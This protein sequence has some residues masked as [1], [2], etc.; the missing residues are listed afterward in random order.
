MAL[1]H[2]SKKGGFFIQTHEFVERALRDHGDSV[3]R[4]AYSM[5]GS[6][7][8][9]EDAMQ[10]TFLKLYESEKT[11][12]SNKHLSNW[13]LKV[14]A[15]YCRNLIRKKKRR[16]VNSLDEL[17]DT[18]KNDLLLS[19]TDNSLEQVDSRLV[20]AKYVQRLSVSLREVVYLFYVE[21]LDQTSIAEVLCIKKGAVK[22]RLHRAHRELRNMIEHDEKELS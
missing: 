20:L 15:N 12:E 4:L 2:V 13:L 10:E 11:F 1:W 6:R 19:T 18:G 22:V 3:F 21:E 16:Q 7:E 17:K 5:L 14:S 9:A 8:Q